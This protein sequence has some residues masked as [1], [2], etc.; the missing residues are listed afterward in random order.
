MLN[1]GP[2]FMPRFQTLVHFRDAGLAICMIIRPDLSGGCPITDYCQPAARG[3]KPQYPV[4]ALHR[5][6]ARQ[7][8][9]ERLASIFASR[10]P[11]SAIELLHG[12]KSTYAR[13]RMV[14]VSKSRPRLV[15]HHLARSQAR[16]PRP[17]HPHERGRAGVSWRS[18]GVCLY[19]TFH[20]VRD[21][22]T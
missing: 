8:T 3:G 17:R 21:S 2:D 14:N 15:S 18:G 1:D 11:A 13:C 20:G 6:A 12:C 16:W 22:S 4:D 19:R 7:P 5:L 10:Y 9:L